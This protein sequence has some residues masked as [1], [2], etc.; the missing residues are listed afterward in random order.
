[1]IGLRKKEKKRTFLIVNLFYI[2]TSWKHKAYLHSNKFYSFYHKLSFRQHPVNVTF[3]QVKCMLVVFL[4]VYS[5]IL[6][7][8][9]FEMYL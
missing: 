3:L 5:F 4:F 2:S 8:S 6:L 1:M 7:V 9:G